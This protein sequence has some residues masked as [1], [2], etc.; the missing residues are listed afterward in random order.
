MRK[1]PRKSKTKL[2]AVELVEAM[3]LGQDWRT[4]NLK[5][6]FK[7]LGA[8]VTKAGWNQYFLPGYKA[9]MVKHTRYSVFGPVA[10]CMITLSMVGMV[11]QL[12]MHHGS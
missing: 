7:W 5:D 4:V 3:S 1:R 10:L 2:F 8:N 9:F 12:D 11:T 6:T